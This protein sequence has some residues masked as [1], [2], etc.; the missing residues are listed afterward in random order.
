MGEQ[1]PKGFGHARDQAEAF[2]QDIEATGHLL[3]EAAQKAERQKS[4][5]ANIWEELQT[6]IRLGRAWRA[7]AYREVPWQSIVYA[8]AALVYFI[9]PFDIVP[10]FIPA[11]G[12]L[13]DATVI[14]FVIRSL[15]QDLTKFLAWE[16]TQDREDPGD[17]A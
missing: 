15:K 3:E 7:G 5:L 9:N 13:D 4:V 11:A 14:G 8:T 1:Q 12:Y 16:K 2:L 10:D 17:A 6:L